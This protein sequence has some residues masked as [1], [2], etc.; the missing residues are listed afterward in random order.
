MF[1][2]MFQESEK[3]TELGLSLSLSHTFILTLTLPFIGLDWKLRIKGR[4]SKMSGYLNIPVIE[5]QRYIFDIIHAK[6]FI[7]KMFEYY[8]LQT[9]NYPAK[10]TAS[11]CLKI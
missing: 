5:N 6:G 10:T 1:Q 7:S 2:K 8:I 4:T 11:I 3:N 9:Q